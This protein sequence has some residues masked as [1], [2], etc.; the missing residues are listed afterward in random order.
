MF[1][2]KSIDDIRINL[3]LLD[4]AW[5]FDLFIST[6]KPEKFRLFKTVKLTSKILGIKFEFALSSFGEYSFLNIKHGA[7]RFN[8]SKF[9]IHK[10]D[11][12]LNCNEINFKYQEAAF[13]NL[14]ECPNGHCK[15][16]MS[17]GNDSFVFH[18]D[19]EIRSDYY[20]DAYKSIF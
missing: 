6:T 12:K 19:I 13:A 9:D 7:D 3:P 4:N 18:S 16:Y 17:N 5:C 8:T 10:F 11:F 2:H 14:S 15:L 20:D 1:K